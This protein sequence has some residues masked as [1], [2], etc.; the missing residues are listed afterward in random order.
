MGRVIAV[1]GI[2]AL[3][4][5]GLKAR[6]AVWWVTIWTASLTIYGLMVSVELS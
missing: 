3:N 5:E 6:P 1:E 4:I 2:V